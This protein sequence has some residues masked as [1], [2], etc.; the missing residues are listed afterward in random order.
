MYNISLL[1]LL[2]VSFDTIVCN[3][4]FNPVTNSRNAFSPSH[5][6]E[7]KIIVESTLGDLGRI[8]ADSWQSKLPSDARIIMEAQ[9]LSGRSDSS[10]SSPFHSFVK[11]ITLK[12]HGTETQFNTFTFTSLPT[13]FENKLPVKFKF[14]VDKLDYER[15]KKPMLY[16]VLY[17]QVIRLY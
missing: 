4:A 6:N 12:P 7:T 13:P 15:T 3:Q 17:T 10:P 14:L 1:F 2:L 16:A 11:T 5:V 8:Q 9:V